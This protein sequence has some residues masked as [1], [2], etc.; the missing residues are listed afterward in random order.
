MG[1]HNK[2][3]VAKMTG[4]VGPNL[5]QVPVADIGIGSRSEQAVAVDTAGA[6][7]VQSCLPASRHIGRYLEEK[8]SGDVSMI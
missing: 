6:G 1:W 2:T 7:C 8:A 5:G 4:Q 3:A